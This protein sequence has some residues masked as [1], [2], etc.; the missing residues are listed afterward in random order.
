MQSV[1]LDTAIAVVF[2]FLLFSVLAYVVQEWIAGLRKSRGKMLEFA[3]SEIFKDAVNLDYDVL[4]YEHPQIDLLKKTKHEL[5]SYIPAVNFATALID[6]M[7]RQ[8]TLVSYVQ[9][10]ETG[11]LKEQETIFSDDAFIRFKKGV[12][13]LQYSELKILLNSFLQNAND[14]PS[15]ELIIVDWFNEYM[16]RV[17]GWYKKSTRKN[18][19]A[20]ATCLVVFFNVDAI[21]LVQNIFSNSQL[22]STLVAAAEKTVAEPSVISNVLKNSTE[23]KLL[24]TDSLFKV[25]ISATADSVDKINLIKEW[26]SVSKGILDS[27]GYNNSNN[28]SAVLNEIQNYRLPIGWELRDSV[29]Q[30]KIDSSKSFWAPLVNR[31]RRVK[32]YFTNFAVIQDRGK[33]PSTPD[34]TVW[35][36]LLGWFIAA[37]GISFG[38]PFW[39]DLLGK[40]V[41]IRQAGIKPQERSANNN[42]KSN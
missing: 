35:T 10:P 36:M 14:Y 29:A 8:S 4:I 22:R 21:H 5:P 7:G 34:R 6:V 20:I 3:I 11:L 15:L 25:R 30:Y 19:I 40:L 32:H 2:V 37:V 28:V 9:D 27:A 17:S 16:K 31:Y 12:E 13:L 1:Y 41:N 18:L 39:F 38:A 33:S 23:N 26:S 24:F 42:S